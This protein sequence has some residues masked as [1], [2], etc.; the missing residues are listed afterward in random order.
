VR[1]QFIFV[2]GLIFRLYFNKSIKAI[3]LKIQSRICSCVV[4]QVKRVRILVNL[5]T[6]RYLIG[7]MAVD[8]CVE[9]YMRGFLSA[10]SVVTE[11]FRLAWEKSEISPT[12]FDFL[13]R[14]RCTNSVKF[15]KNY[16]NIHSNMPCNPKYIFTLDFQISLFIIETWH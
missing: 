4:K 1:P 2:M 12:E 9:G 7:A 11:I 5:L 14:S 15:L 8:S 13:R 10:I 16:R 6:P 3:F